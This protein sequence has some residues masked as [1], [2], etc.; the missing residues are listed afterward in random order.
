MVVFVEPAMVKNILIPG[1]YLPFFLNFFLAL[2]L[3]L[4]IVFANSRRGFLFSLGVVVLLILRLF[5][6]GN[7]LNAILITTLVL[8]LDYY[9]THHH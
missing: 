9:F 1:L 3:T 2:F 6:L 5:Q 8:T 4:A 7:I